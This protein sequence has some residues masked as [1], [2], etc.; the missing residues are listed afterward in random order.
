MARSF[1]APDSFFGV[2]PVVK[3]NSVTVH[4]PAGDEGWGPNNMWKD[5]TETEH[6][7]LRAVYDL[8]H[9]DRNTLNMTTKAKL[10]TWVL[11]L[12]IPIDDA[13]GKEDSKI[14]LISKLGYIKSWHR[15]QI[16]SDGHV[17]GALHGTI[18]MPRRSNA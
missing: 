12:G 9:T 11:D 2:A 17:H 14:D 1:V 7:F 15:Y 10:E 18:F 13:H 5:E 8:K 16:W 6:L 3:A 4:G